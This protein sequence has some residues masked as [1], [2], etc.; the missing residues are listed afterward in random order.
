MEI[1]GLSMDTPSRGQSGTLPSCF[2]SPTINNYALGSLFSVTF[3]I[4]LCVLL[5]TLLVTVAPK[6]S[7][8]V[9]LSSVLSTRRPL[10]ALQRNYC[11][12][13]RLLSG[14]NYSAT[15]L[16]DTGVESPKGNR[17]NRKMED[18]RAIITYHVFE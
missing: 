12:L 6:R 16:N 1:F 17:M 9:L 18:V 4:F 14:M 8:D 11:L 15:G 5:V 13:N 3:F 2:S 10:W 7:G